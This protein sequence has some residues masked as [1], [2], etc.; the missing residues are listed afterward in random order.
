MK[1]FLS[2]SVSMASF[3]NVVRKKK[4]KHYLERDDLLLCSNFTYKSFQFLYLHL[5][6]NLKLFVSISPS[7]GQNEDEHDKSSAEAT[8]TGGKAMF[9]PRG[10]DDR[11]S[12]RTQQLSEQMN[13]G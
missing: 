11:I 1:Q 6:F 5:Q 10:T 12:A 3:C 8:I 9:G 13:A 7:L 4:S 2:Q